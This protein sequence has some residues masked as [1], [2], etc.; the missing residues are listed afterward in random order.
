[1]IANGVVFAYGSGESNVQA[2]PELGLGANT[3]AIRIKNS[4]P[5]VIYALD[6]DTGK[7]LWNSG[8]A[9]KSFVHFGGLSVNNGRVYLGTFDSTLDSFGLPGR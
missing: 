9:M 2:T 6:G 4:H 8:D 7:E 1:M 3:S 5:A